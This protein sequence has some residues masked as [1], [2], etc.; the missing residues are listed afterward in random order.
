M[1]GSYSTGSVCGCNRGLA[2]LGACDTTA[3]RSAR[4]ESAP[5]AEGAP[6]GKPLSVTQGHVR[7]LRSRSSQGP[8]RPVVDD[9]RLA[10]MTDLMTQ[11][12]PNDRGLRLA[13]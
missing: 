2:G 4:A 12:S 1:V 3:N 5:A 13:D 10:A 8:P 7:N 11:R 6:I 9:V